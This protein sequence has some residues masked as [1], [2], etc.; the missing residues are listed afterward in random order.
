MRCTSWSG[1]VGRYVWPPSARGS[2][3]S[4]NTMSC[5]PHTA[6][7]LPTTSITKPHPL[8][9]QNIPSFA[10]RTLHTAH[11]TNET[12]MSLSTSKAVRTLPNAHIGSSGHTRAK[13]K[14]KPCTLQMHGSRAAPAH[15][16]WLPAQHQGQAALQLSAGTSQTQMAPLPTLL[17]QP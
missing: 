12:G 5:K 11:H 7:P 13:T 16:S 4:R 1:V 6:Q 9:F 10:R 8:R 17:C 2:Q 3:P 15:T 14:I